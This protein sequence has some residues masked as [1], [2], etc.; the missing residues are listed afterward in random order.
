MQSIALLESVVSA[1][2]G[3]G[4][5]CA[6]FHVRGLQ[7]EARLQAENALIKSQ[8]EELKS[9]EALLR[10]E[11]NDIS[12][13]NTRLE[14]LLEESRKL[15]DYQQEQFELLSQ[16]VLRA[17]TEK[18]EEKAA[19]D[20]YEQ[21][22][23]SREGMEKAVKPMAIQSE[24]MMAAPVESSKARKPRTTRSKKAGSPQESA[25]SAVEL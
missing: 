15:G 18:L 16:K 14:T 23:P 19:K 6:L 7:R 24:A 3:F 13:S 9:T 2:L 1:L 20:H 5:G 4:L 17:I 8:L 11:I 12:L 21:L 25:L 10:L 22:I